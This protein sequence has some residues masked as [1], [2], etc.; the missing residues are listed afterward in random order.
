[1]GLHQDFLYQ[2]AHHR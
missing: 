2:H 1:M